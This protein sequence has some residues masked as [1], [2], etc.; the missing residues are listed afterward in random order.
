MRIDIAQVMRQ[1]RSFRV[2][3][4]Q[5]NDTYSALMKYGANKISY[6]SESLI[7]DL[8]DTVTPVQL[9]EYLH[10]KGI[11]VDRIDVIAESEK[12]LRRTILEYD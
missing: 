7:V 8:D 1:T 12:E 11:E 5:I 4:A 3:T 2:R 6:E 10:N 9:V